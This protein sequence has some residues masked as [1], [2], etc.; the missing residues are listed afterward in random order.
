MAACRETAGHI[1]GA[2]VV[3]KETLDRD[4]LGIKKITTNSKPVFIDAADRY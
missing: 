1:C 2:E 3:L 4:G